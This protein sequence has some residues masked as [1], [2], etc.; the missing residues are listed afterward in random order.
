M[1][2]DACSDY[3]ASEDTQIQAED[4]TNKLAFISTI[5]TNDNLNSKYRRPIKCLIPS[6]F[7]ILYHYTAAEYLPS[8]LESG[9]TQGDV[10]ITPTGGFNAPWLTSDRDP[11]GHGLISILD[12]RAVR[13]TVKI[14]A[15][16]PRLKWWPKFAKG[17]V[18]SSWYDTLDRTGG[19]KSETWYIYRGVVPANWF[20]NIERLS[21][22][23]SNVENKDLHHSG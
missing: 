5:I 7:M 18:E 23:Y 1:L 16:D 19:G 10:P 15:N 21:E 14:P 9:I 12:K 6:I 4:A 13:I 22:M 8:I 11:A 3:L 20:L 17:R 2:N